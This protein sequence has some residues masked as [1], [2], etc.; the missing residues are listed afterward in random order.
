MRSAIELRTSTGVS[1]SSAS[2]RLPTQASAKMET[3]T[4]ASN[5]NNWQASATLSVQAVSPLSNPL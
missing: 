5:P 2:H 4:K 1:A 3:D